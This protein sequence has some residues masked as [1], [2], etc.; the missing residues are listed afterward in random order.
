M[1]CCGPKGNETRTQLDIRWDQR[2]ASRLCGGKDRLSYVR[3]F[4]TELKRFSGRVSLACG[5]WGG[6]GVGGGD[7]SN[8]GRDSTL[9]VLM[10]M[11]DEAGCE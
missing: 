11:L 3:G 6:S 7:A 8:S 9:L 5:E 1:N 2:P 4:T 10:F